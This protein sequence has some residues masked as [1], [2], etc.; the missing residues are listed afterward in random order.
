MV[1]ATIWLIDK[2][3]YERLTYSSQTLDHYVRDQGHEV[4]FVDRLENGFY[5]PVDIPSDRC[6]VM[7]GSHGFT[8]HI[9][10]TYKV[11]PGALGIND[12]TQAT[13]YMSALPLN[14]F[15]NRNANMMTWKMF[16]HRARELFFDHDTNQLFIRPNSG[17]KTFAGQVVKFGTI[18]HDIET[19]DKLSS[20]MDD[21]LILVGECQ[22]LRG[23]FRFVIADGQVVAGSEYRWDGKLDIRRDWTPECEAL[24]QQVASHEWQVDVAYTCDVAL[25]EDCP[26]IVELNGFSCA[27]LYACDLNLVVRHVTAAAQKEFYSVLSET[28]G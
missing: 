12:R 5:P 6:V 27:G 20:V 3:I 9:S 25:T 14:W 28:A 15:L 26:R 19:L 1:P 24:A 16:K 18:D 11:Q 22:D 4:V 10:Q 7:Y 21:T 8:R 23:E 17:F 13:S 2:S